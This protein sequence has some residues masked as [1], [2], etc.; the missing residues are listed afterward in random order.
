LTRSQ[1]RLLLVAAADGQ[2]HARERLVE[3]FLPNVAVMARGYA[4]Y[5]G[6]EHRELMQE[7]VVGLLQALDRYDHR[8]GVP[9]WAYASWWVRQAMQKVVSELTRHVVLSDRAHRRLARLKDAHR[10]HVQAHGAEPSTAELAA[11]TDLPRAQ[12]ES[13]R[14]VESVPRR[15]EETLPGEEGAG[16]T[17]GDLVADP[18]SEDGYQSVV[19]RA[20][21]RALPALS[22]RLEEREREIVFAHFGLGRPALTLRQIAERLDLSVERVRQLEE[23]A[24][25]KLHDAATAVDGATAAA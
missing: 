12:V 22:R 19:T 6:V 2:S 17:V 10:R 20:A 5:R 25:A 21:A 13:L 1:E 7:G 9:F 18:A 24:L 11:A 8:K 16:A 14:W 15:L 3:A 23:R 4:G